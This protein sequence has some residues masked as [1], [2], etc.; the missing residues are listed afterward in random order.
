MYHCHWN[1]TLGLLFDPLLPE[2]EKEHLFST[3]YMPGILATILGDIISVLVRLIFPALCSEVRIPAEIWA[4]ACVLT[5]PVL[6]SYYPVFSSSVSWQLP[7]SKQGLYPKWWVFIFLLV[8][9]HLW[10]YNLLLCLEG[11]HIILNE[12][13]CIFKYLQCWMD[14]HTKGNHDVWVWS[15]FLT[16]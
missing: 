14:G 8:P 6:S 15:Y 4:Q 10:G 9:Q 3:Y 11:C 16:E 5:K 12:L 1:S 2:E 7:N 13:L